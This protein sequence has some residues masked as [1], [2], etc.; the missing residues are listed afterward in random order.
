MKSVFC[1]TCQTEITVIE[2]VGRR[3]ECPKCR[4]D[5]HVCKNCA[6]YDAKVYNECKETQAEVVR[7]KDRS[8][9]CD[10]FSPRQG[11]MGEVKDP[12]EALREAA[13]ALFKKKA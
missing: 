10:Y 7:E 8:N 9:H 2:K 12:A 3:E 11:K 6:F 4:A 1:F 13:E 5:V